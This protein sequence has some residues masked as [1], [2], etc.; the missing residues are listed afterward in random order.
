MIM[1][2]LWGLLLLL[3]IPALIIIYIIK[4]DHKEKDVSSTY[5]W[6]LS[7]RFLKKRLPI[8]RMTS[9]LAFI[10]QLTILGLLAF[11]ATQPAVALGQVSGHIVIIDAS[12]SM[13]TEQDGVTRFEAAVAQAKEMAQ[14]GFC[15]SMTVIIASET[16]ACLVTGGSMGEAI[17]ALDQATCGY[18]TCNIYESM[19]LAREAYARMGSAK[20]TFF[21]DTQYA[22]VENVE[23]VNMH[24]GE[25]NIA[26]TSLTHMSGTFEGTVVSYGEDREVTVGFSIDGVV[27]DT[28]IVSCV[29]GEPARIK[30]TTDQRNFETA[31]LYFEAEDA[32]VHDNRFTVVGKSS[33]KVTV[34]VLGTETLFFEEGFKALG[35]CDVTVKKHYNTSL[36]GAYDLYLFSGCVSKS[37]DNF[38]KNSL[39]IGFTQLLVDR[40]PYLGEI[41]TYAIRS[42]RGGGNISAFLRDDLTV[43]PLFKDTETAILDV[44]INKYVETPF[45][46]GGITVLPPEQ[47]QT[48][49]ESICGGISGEVMGLSRVLDNGTRHYL[50]LFP[51]SSTNL[52]MTPAFMI[53]LRN[54][55]TLALPPS[56]PKKEYTVGETVEMTLKDHAKSPAITQPWGD[57]L[58]LNGQKPT[59][60]P[61]EPGLHT[62]TYEL[63]KQPRKASFFV[64]IPEAEYETYS[65]DSIFL[66]KPL[67]RGSQGQLLSTSM[68]PF[69]AALL[70]ALLIFEWG[71]HYR[72][73]R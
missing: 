45:S 2:N 48:S 18:G 15:S 33:E 4:Q 16:P 12:A 28:A 9:L 39:T 17:N 59:F 72:G 60:V 62:L 7:E 44:H 20:V 1:Q 24:R 10:L 58:E 27:V 47:Q 37:E 49:W 42:P 50:F 73:K 51:I 55:A 3:S 65:A 68:L 52:A 35:N 22:E 53:L 61:T 69:A 41:M 30:F 25:K 29:D 54:A 32:L 56:L 14:S 19:K 67:E 64:R 46:R 70:S 31:T 63:N 23:V 66:S 40:Q 57:I 8:R 5:L 71:Y 26:I 21:T 36:D 34:L 38:P 11:S 6:H 43:D 13:Q